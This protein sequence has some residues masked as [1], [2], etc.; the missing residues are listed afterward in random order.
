MVKSVVCYEKLASVSER[1]GRGTWQFVTSRGTK[2][3]QSAA[4]ISQC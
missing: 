2:C 4:V 1:D 3:L